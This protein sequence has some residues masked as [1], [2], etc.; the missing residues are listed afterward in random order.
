MA[1]MMTCNAHG[2][3]D[4]PRC[5]SPGCAE[6]WRPYS[7]PGPEPAAELCAAPGCDMPRPCPLHPDARQGPQIRGR[8]AAWESPV[9]APTLGASV[10]LRF[11]W[12]TAAV[13]PSGVLHVGR[14][15]GDECGRQIDEFDNVSRR[16][17]IVRVDGTA[18]VVEDQ[19]S[20]NGTTV[21]GEPATAYT[22]VP[23]R[24]GD[25]LGFGAHLRALVEIA[26]DA[27]DHG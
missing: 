23:L 8:Q 27:G 13:P 24:H 12:G 15:F 25:A 22:P 20:T 21:N 17:A 2:P 19:L 11:P 1:A 7:A 6:L 16:H 4:A 18:I 5:P 14:D 9:T 26:E 10:R 3:F